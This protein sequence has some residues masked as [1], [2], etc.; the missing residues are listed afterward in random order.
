MGKAWRT[1]CRAESFTLSFFRKC[2]ESLRFEYY[3]A[4]YELLQFEYLNLDQTY[5]PG[6]GTSHGQSMENSLPC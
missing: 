3:R 5:C 2:G 1:L 6:L 4:G